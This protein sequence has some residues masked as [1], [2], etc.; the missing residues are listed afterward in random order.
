MFTTNRAIGKMSGTFR[1]GS[2][3]SATYTGTMSA[4][5]RAINKMSETS[6]AR[7]KMDA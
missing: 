6:R 3:T 5:N 7:C 2:K 1:A 4:T